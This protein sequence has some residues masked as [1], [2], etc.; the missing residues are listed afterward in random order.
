MLYFLL[1][2]CVINTVRQARNC[3]GYS[4]NA[5]K[6]NT[7]CLCLIISTA[8]V[9]GNILQRTFCILVAS[10]NLCK[11]IHLEFFPFLY[12]LKRIHQLSERLCFFQR[13]IGRASCRE[14]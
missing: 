14:R 10:E 7:I 13:Q 11:N 4:V 9:V 1:C 6:R 2:S 12:S 3:C 5:S 8:S